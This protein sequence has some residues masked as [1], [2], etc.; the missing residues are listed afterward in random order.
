MHFFGGIGVDGA[1]HADYS[2]EGG[3]GIT[4][5]GALV[6]FGESLAGGGAAGV[7][8]LD[9]GADRLIEFLCEIPGGLQVDDV[10][11]GEFLALELTGVG[12]AGAGAVGVHG[13]PLMGVFAVAQV[14]GFLEGETQSCREHGFFRLQ[15]KGVCGGIYGDALKCGGDRGIVGGGG[16]ESFLRQSPYRG[17]RDR[18]GGAGEFVGDG[19]VVGGRSDDGDVVKILGGG[20]DHGGAANV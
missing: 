11:V 1:I 17:L 20:A 10:V 6:G 8:V 3:D 16:G 15:L 5:E 4:F 19:G 13:G 12:H 18:A 14:E 7:G 2:A 9:D